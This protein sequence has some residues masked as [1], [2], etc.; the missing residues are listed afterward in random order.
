MGEYISLLYTQKAILKKKKSIR[1]KGVCV[2]PQSTVDSLHVRIISL[3]FKPNI[4]ENVSRSQT[5]DNI[6]PFPAILGMYQKNIT[7]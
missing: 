7:T 1:V 3:D 5:N 4:F 6:S 2:F